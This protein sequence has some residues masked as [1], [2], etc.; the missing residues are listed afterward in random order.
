MNIA[1]VGIGG[2]AS[3]EFAAALLRLA[4]MSMSMDEI[5]EVMEALE[6]EPAETSPRSFVS[7]PRVQ[8]YKHQGPRPETR[9]GRP[10]SSW[11][12]SGLVSPLGQARGP[13]P[14]RDLTAQVK[15]ER[16][17]RG[18]ARTHAIRR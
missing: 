3:D 9:Y 12:S 10:W 11:D 2:V 18:P 16:S 5:M 7:R 8:K 15:P 17:S 1:L 6:A 13:P 4:T 14:K